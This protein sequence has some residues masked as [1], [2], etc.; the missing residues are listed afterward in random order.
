MSKRFTAIESSRE[1]RGRLSRSSCTKRGSLAGWARQMWAVHAFVSGIEYLITARLQLHDQIVVLGIDKLASEPP[2]SL[3]VP[4]T[5][6][7]VAAISVVSLAKVDR[8]SCRAKIR[9]KR[10]FCGHFS[11]S[12]T[13]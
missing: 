8:R 3:R 6:A 11:F 12:N 2:H 10:S 5:P 1:I 7:P 13:N 9:G 4:I